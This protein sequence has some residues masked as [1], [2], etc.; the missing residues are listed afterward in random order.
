MTQIDTTPSTL[1]STHAKGFRSCSHLTWEW[2]AQWFS[3]LEVH[4]HSFDVVMFDSGG[5]WSMYVAVSALVKVPSFLHFLP[6]PFPYFFSS[7][8]ICFSWCPHVFHVYSPFKY[9][10]SMPPCPHVPTSGE[11]VVHSHVAPL[12]SL[13]LCFGWLTFLSSLSTS[14]GVVV[15]IWMFSTKALG[16]RLWFLHAGVDHRNSFYFFQINQG[17]LISLA[18]N[19][20]SSL[21]TL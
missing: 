7:H 9:F 2:L 3:N 6:T 5:W 18:H 17:W 14:P 8:Q 15:W 4:W 11:P 1:P 13:Q 16:L 19:K 12:F 10:A 21:C 20:Q